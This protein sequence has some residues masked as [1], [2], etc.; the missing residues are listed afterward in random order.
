[1]LRRAILG[2]VACAWALSIGLVVAAEIRPP[3]YGPCVCSSVTFVTPESIDAD[4]WDGATT[5]AITI[6]LGGG[7]TICYDAD[8]L[9]VAAMWRGGLLDFSKTHHTSY[10]GQLPPRPAATPYY[11][12]LKA[13]GWRLT[14]GEAF[15]KPPSL[16]GYYLQGDQV[17][18]AYHVGDRG[19]LESPTSSG[20]A[21]QRRVRVEPGKDAI[22]MLVGKLVNGAT[23]VSENRG[24]IKSSDGRVTVLLDTVAG[25]AKLSAGGDSLHVEIPASDTACEF[26]VRITTAGEV[27]A[28]DIQQPKEQHPPLDFAKVDAGG[29]RRWTREIVSVG[30]LG[31]ETGAYAI[32]E[33]AV[34]EKP[35]GLWMRLSAIDFFADGRCAVATMPGDVWIVSWDGDDI[36]NALWQRYATGL[37]EPLG[38]KVVDGK[39]YV[40]GRDRITRL[41]DL[42]DDG[43]ADFYEQFHAYGPVGPGYHAFQTDLVTDKEGNFYYAIG[44]RKSPSIGEVVRVSPDGKSHEVIAEHFR[45][46]NGMGFGGPHDWLTIADNPDGKFPT[47]GVIVGKGQHYGEE[48]GPRTAPFLYLLPPKVDTSS[49]SQCWTDVKRFGPLSGALIHT[50]YSTSSISYVMVQDSKPNPSGFA[51]HL[52]FGFKSGPMR[53]AVSP[54]DGQMYIAG[55]R[56]WDSN[57]AVDGALSRM[58]FTGKAACMAI[59]ARAKQAGVELTFSH[60]LL[61]ST[62]DYDNF[63]AARISDT[64]NDE[65][66]IDDVELVDE[67][68]VLVRFTPEVLDPDQNID[69]KETAADTQGRSHYIAVPPLAITFN[70][71]SALEQPVKG[72]VYCTINGLE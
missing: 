28:R 16:D 6:D 46:P 54:R 53:L 62:V 30:T 15:A 45:C 69:R 22:S 51:V 11:L 7:A 43:E 67:R 72:T 13:A 23:T 66:D 68:T 50:S 29:P 18:L 2:C 63:S 34:P 42:N 24:Y 64:V 27:S 65:V 71:K 38:L 61:K 21:V 9:A 55:Q 70:I 26:A 1:M 8:R 10:K 41:H 36:H 56:G 39:I 12:E 17:A 59:A 40:R 20:A 5:R 44:G 19:I 52:P 57:A 33:I 35:Y 25:D 32:D 49:G 60:P 3:E 4:T 58:R 48:G 31:E 14:S 47:G 37:Y